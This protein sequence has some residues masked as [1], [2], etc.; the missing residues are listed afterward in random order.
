M[1]RCTHFPSHGTS[2]NG[3]FASFPTNSSSLY[4]FFLPKSLVA[5]NAPDAAGSFSASRGVGMPTAR[6][7]YFFL[8]DGR[9]SGGVSSPGLASC[10]D[11]RF[12]LRFTWLRFLSRSLSPPGSESALGMATFGDAQVLRGVG[13]GEGLR[14]V[15]GVEEGENP[16]GPM[17]SFWMLSFRAFSK[18]KAGFPA[19][20]KGPSAADSC[21]VHSLILKSFSGQG[22]VRTS[23]RSPGRRSGSEKSQHGKEGL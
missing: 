11:L 13:A 10:W 1:G 15:L 17:S 7:I 22:S 8:M 14:E 2:L 16:E 23:S 9:I 3:V 6:W 18:L 5:T 12:F 19:Q 20:T 4:T 21:P